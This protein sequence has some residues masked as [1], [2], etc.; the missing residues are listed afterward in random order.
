MHLSGVSRHWNAAEVH[1]AGLEVGRPRP[2][3]GARKM[4]VLGMRM[5]PDAPRPVRIMIMTVWYNW[6]GVRRGA[7]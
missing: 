4:S 2:D 5:T 6:G 3:L 1:L 7:R